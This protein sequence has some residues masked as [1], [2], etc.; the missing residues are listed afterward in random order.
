MPLTSAIQPYYPHWPRQYAEEAERLQP[1]F[2]L[3]AVE[4]HHVGSTAVPELSAKPEI[5]ILIVV[6]VAQVPDEWSQLLHKLGYRRCGDL[7]PGHHFFKRDAGSVRTLKV[8]VCHQG[9][10]N[11]SE[12]L[13]FRDHLRRHPADRLRYQELKLKLER[14]NTRGIREYLSGKAPFINSI[15]GRST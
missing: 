13:R 11:I 5:D 1:I 3:A 12:Q 4:M 6:N 14:E 15:L 8:H 2:G 7:S 10:P 9:H